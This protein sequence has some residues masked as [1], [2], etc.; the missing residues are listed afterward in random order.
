M[1]TDQVPGLRCYSHPPHALFFLHCSPNPKGPCAID[2]WLMCQMPSRFPWLSSHFAASTFFIRHGLQF[3]FKPQRISSFCYTAGCLLFLQGRTLASTA[4]R[5]A[6][7]YISLEQQGPGRQS[8]HFRLSDIWEA[9][10]A[11]VSRYL[12]GF[13]RVSKHQAYHLPDLCTTRQSSSLF[14][15]LKKHTHIPLKI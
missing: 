13:I 5:I 1:R 2:F 10:T 3:P 15:I 12:G 8:F 9:W 6:L 7:M 14:F 4:P 11:R